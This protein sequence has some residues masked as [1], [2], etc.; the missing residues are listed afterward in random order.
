MKRIR[1]VALFLNVN[2]HKSH[3]GLSELAAMNELETNDLILFVNVK[4]TAYKA[5]VSPEL[6][7]YYRS[8]GDRLTL[9]DFKKLP[10][11]FGGERLVLSR[12]VEKQLCEILKVKLKEVG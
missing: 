9:N 5:M 12:D 4:M 1:A 10:E 11:L 8:P 2:M 7:A 6:V 3:H